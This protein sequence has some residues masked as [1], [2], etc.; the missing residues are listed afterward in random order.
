M[1]E[2]F[3]ACFA[4]LKDPRS[5]PAERHN[6]AEIVIIALCAVLSGGLTAVDMAQYG[7]AKQE[8]L[9][10]FLTLKHGIPSHDT[11]SRVF[12]LLDPDQ[13]RACFRKLTVGRGSPARR[14][15]AIDGKVARQAPGSAGPRL[16][17]VSAWDCREGL[18][19]GQVAARAKSR[20]TAAVLELLPTLPLRGAVITADA[21]NCRPE[22]AG[23]IVRRGGDYALALKRN[24]RALH[25]LVSRF[26]DNLRP[27]AR[28][29]ATTVTRQHGRV[30]TRTGLVA[31][32]IAWL[33]PRHR[34]PGLAAVGKL[35]RT[36]R[37]TNGLAGRE[38]IEVAYYLLS[39]PLSPA[40]F[41]ETV[42]SHWGVENRLHWA[43]N[44]VM[45]EDQ[46]RSRSDNSPY[47]LAILR[48]MALN[49]MRRDTSRVSLRAKLNLAAWQDAFLTKLLS[50]LGAH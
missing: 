9:R 1:L 29:I 16:H 24:H 6:L 35:V 32:D 7:T 38:T 11:F 26:L 17:M 43:L 10:R 45:H 28:A 8:Y 20:E 33:P 48:H 14:V 19:L 42:R 15:I 37:P 18:V 40:R 21:L 4:E 13:F 47:N 34:W 50:G 49:V 36:R 3:C 39:E 27:E 25:T 41:G 30:E 23:E 46:A 44:V 2:D 5:G 31:A 12:R 22:I